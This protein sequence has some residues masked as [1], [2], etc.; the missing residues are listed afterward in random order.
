[1]KTALWE[2]RTMAQWETLES[3]GLVRL[4][5]VPYDEPYDVSYVDTWGLSD[6]RTEREKKRIA[7]LIE[8]DGVWN[9]LG[10]YRTDRSQPFETGDAVCGFVGTDRNGYE[11]SIASN[12]IEELR[13]ALKNRCRE[14]RK[15]GSTIQRVNTKFYEISEVKGYGKK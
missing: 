6:G 4:Q 8:S 7:D 1:M 5:Y 9:L 3:A 14:C 10:Q 11:P 2:A 12:T 13:K 15:P